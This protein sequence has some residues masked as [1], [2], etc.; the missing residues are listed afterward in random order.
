MDTSIPRVELAVHFVCQMA[1]GNEAGSSAPCGGDAC[2]GLPERRRDDV[3][4][5]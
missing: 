3:V 1:Q 4:D 5:Q 2:G